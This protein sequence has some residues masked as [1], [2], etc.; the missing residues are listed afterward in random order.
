M[1]LA[2]GLFTRAITF[3]LI[4]LYARA[5]QPEGYARLEL[6]TT[7]V[8]LLFPLL[9]LSLYEGLFRFVAADRTRAHNILSTVLPF[10]LIGIAFSVALLPALARVP[11]IE[12][13]A[14]GVPL[15]FSLSILNS[16][17][18]QFLRGK[19][20]ATSFAIGGVVHGVTLAV[21]A[22]SFLLILRAGVEGYIFAMAGGYVSSISYLVVRGRLWTAVRLQYFS[23]GEL[24]PIFRFSLP[25]MLTGALWWVINSVN[26]VF[27]AE[28]RSLE[29]LGVFAGASRVSLMVT[30][31]VV[32]AMQAWQIAVNEEHLSLDFEAFVVSVY[33]RFQASVICICAALALAADPIVWLLL[34]RD[35]TQSAALVPL[36]LLSSSLLASSL[37]FTSLQMAKM[38]V[39]SILI[40][41]VLSAVTVFIGNWYLVPE[42]GAEGAA[43]ANIVGFAVLAFYHYASV[44]FSLRIG[45]PSSQ[46][47]GGFAGLGSLC[48]PGLLG[49]VGFPS[50]TFQV[51]GIAIILTLYGGPLVAA[52]LRVSMR[53]KSR[54]S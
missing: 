16:F 26:R 50:I 8:D 35:F 49:L 51:L 34:G 40:A 19:G 42:L 15:L 33:T 39:R 41:S 54:P 32:V 1:L 3:L 14:W 48:V 47:V 24:G 10:G 31:V 46:M 4:P 20:D 38:N 36:L 9:S 43:L 45:L 7:A 30:T 53:V 44:R 27:L 2:G 12:N 5:L 22:S 13:L 21:L 18:G 23:V 25:L 11:G 29:E 37:F 52:L 6:I 17:A 28:F